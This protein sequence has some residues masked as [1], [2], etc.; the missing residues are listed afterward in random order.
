MKTKI[1]ESLGAAAFMS[2]RKNIFIPKIT[3]N[4]RDFE[5]D[6]RRTVFEFYDT[7]E[8]PTVKNRTFFLS[9]C[10]SLKKSYNGS[11]FPRRGY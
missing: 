9:L 2:S 5:K 7:G 10:F 3:T 6:V 8:F 11:F 1:S 4:L